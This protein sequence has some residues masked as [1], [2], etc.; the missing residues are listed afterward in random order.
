M[1]QGSHGKIV[2]VYAEALH[3][4]GFRPFAGADSKWQPPDIPD[5]LMHE[6]AAAWLRNLL[7]QRPYKHGPT[8]EANI[9]MFRAALK[10][11]ERHINS[12][13]D[14][15]GLCKSLPRRIGELI[16]AEGDRLPY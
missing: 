16:D 11:C 9:T 1:Y 14:V 5:L 2:N 15:D 8:L 7:R 4:H 3:K 10:D 12:Q 6:T 13:Y